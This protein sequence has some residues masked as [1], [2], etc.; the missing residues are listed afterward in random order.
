MALH[1][2]L[3]KVYALSENDPEFVQ[4]IIN[5]FVSEIPLDLERIKQGIEDKNHQQCYEYAHKIKPSLDLMGL[6]LAFE[7]MLQIESWAKADGKK[8]E[9]KEIYKSVSQQIEKAIKEIKKDFNLK[10]VNS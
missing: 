3:A 5:L 1:Y 7:E 10:I 6:N 4:Q 9:I 8:K 2:N